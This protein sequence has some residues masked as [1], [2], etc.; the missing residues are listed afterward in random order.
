MNESEGGM[1]VARLVTFLG[2]GRYDKA[3]DRH[4]YDLAEYEFQGQKATKTP[5]VCHALAELIDP[6]DVA[7]L[8]TGEAEKLHGADLQE[9]LRAGNCLAPRFVRIPTGQTPA[10]LWKQFD[11]IKAELRDARGPVMLDITHGFRS[12][13]FFAAAVTA[14][15]HAVGENLSDLRI[16]YAAYD[17]RNRETSITPIW[18]LTEFVALLDWSR[19]LATFLRTGR[20]QEAGRTTVR[21]GRDLRK[22]WFQGGKQGEEPNLKELGEA[23]I[24]FGADLETLRTGD[25]LIGRGSVRSSAA[26]LLASARTAKEHVSRHAPPLADI[27]DRV[28]AMAEPLS[29][30]GEDLSGDEGRKAVTALAD[31]YLR[32]GRHIEAAATVREGWVNLYAPRMAL[33]PASGHFNKDERDR[34]ERRACESDTTF[35]EITDWRNDVL[36]AQ[37][38]ATGQ[39]SA[40]VIETVST[41]VKK[42]KAA[43]ETARGACFVNLSNHTKE[44]WEEAQMQA[45]RDLAERIEDV[46]FPAV[47]PNADEKAIMLLADDCLA[48]IPREATHALVQGEF[49]LTVELVRRLQARGITCLAATSTRNVEEESDGRKVST[50]TF[51]RFRAYPELGPV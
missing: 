6:S 45:A 40:G 43:T 17:A 11:V 25:L 27:L 7:V 44:K 1:K 34:A 33:V 9:A 28:M 26:R 42:L 30:A 37:Y 47:P 35:R 29:N 24:R 32:F 12:Q 16:C 50:F 22:T 21:L 15:V 41:L 18:E 39:D 46:T 3:L 19:A 51:V 48:K 10:E 23:L 2:L 4:V 5:Y 20:A 49:T 14:F 13:P 36:H 8:A 31:L 38:R